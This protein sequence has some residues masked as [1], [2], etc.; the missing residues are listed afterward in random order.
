MS[1]IGHSGY[2][3]SQK[4][5]E[6]ITSWFLNTHFPR[7]K[8]DVQ[9]THRGM[10]RENL[11]GACDVLGS[12]SRPRQFIIEIDTHLPR[13]IYI[14][15]L[16]HELVHL[17]QWVKGSLRIKSGRT[18]WNGENVSNWDYRSQPH[19][20][21]AHQMEDKLMVDYIFYSTGEWWGDE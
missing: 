18:H 11:F 12:E 8:I 9:I 1:Y 13:E 17:G 2:G 14:K 4:L 3:Y 20:I 15:T 7:H 16:L 6:D 19:E 10:K 21:E 5:C